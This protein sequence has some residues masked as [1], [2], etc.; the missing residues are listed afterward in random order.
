MRRETESC[1]S[2]S[3]PGLWSCEVTEEQ[4]RGIGDLNVQWTCLSSY[5]GDGFVDY[6]CKRI[7]SHSRGYGLPTMSLK[8][9]KPRIN[10]VSRFCYIYYFGIISNSTESRSSTCQ[11]WDFV[12][13]FGNLKD[14]HCIRFDEYPKELPRLALPRPKEERIICQSLST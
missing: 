13:V 8:S 7:V 6:R 10:A 5:R 12:N 3:G 1:S 14:T 4:L 2:V 11:N 9:A